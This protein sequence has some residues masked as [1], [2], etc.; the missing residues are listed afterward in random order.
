MHWLKKKEINLSLSFGP[1]AAVSTANSHISHEAVQHRVPLPPT[2]KHHEAPPIAKQQNRCV[3][4]SPGVSTCW[5]PSAQLTA[6]HYRFK[7]TKDSLRICKAFAFIFGVNWLR[8]CG[9][10]ASFG[11]HIYLARDTLILHPPEKFLVGLSCISFVN[12]KPARIRRA[13]GSA[14]SA[15]IALNSS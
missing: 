6:T 9:V 15:F 3:L 10:T 1:H 14:E 5:S 11:R 7:L 12:P 2:S 8:H 13:L 4:P